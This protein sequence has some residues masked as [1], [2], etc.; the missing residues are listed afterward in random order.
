MNLRVNGATFYQYYHQD[1]TVLVGDT[2]SYAAPSDDYADGTALPPGAGEGTPGNDNLSGGSGDDA[3]NG[4]GGNDSIRSSG[5]NDTIDGGDGQDTLSLFGA[6]SNFTFS[7]DTQTG[8]VTAIDESGLEGR[9]TLTGIEAV[10]F[11]T[12]NETYTMPDLVGYYGTPGDDP[13]IQG[14]H[15]DNLIFG[16]AGADYLVGLGGDDRLDGGTGADV[17]E[18]GTGDDWYYVADTGDSVVEAP[19]EGEDDRIY[20][21]VSYILPTGQAV[22]TIIATDAD[23]TMPLNFTAMLLPN[24]HRKPAQTS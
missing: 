17:M 20:A 6:R 2:S 7:L 3:I 1:I 13:L 15:R 24:D 22:E 10:D 23:G 21:S 11:T 18:G 16:L 4:G 19:G 14:S 12:D 5:G 9:M 8:I